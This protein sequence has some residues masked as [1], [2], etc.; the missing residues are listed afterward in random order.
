[1]L[2][3]IRDVTPIFKYEKL[4]IINSFIETPISVARHENLALLVACKA[5]VNGACMYRSK[6]NG[7]IILM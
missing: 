2:P 7:D 3:I 6:K 5:V 1:M 4:N